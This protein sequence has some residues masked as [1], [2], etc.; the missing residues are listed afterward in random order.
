MRRLSVGSLW[1]V[2]LLLLN[3]T[4]STA[5]NPCVTLR[6]TLGD[7]VVEIFCD[8]APLTS[9]NFLRYVD[10]DRFAGA[11]F[12]RVVTLAN[13]PGD[14]ITIEVVQGGLGFAESNLRLPPVAHETTELTGIQHTDGVISMARLEPGTASSEFFFCI[15]AQPH[16]DFGG[17]RNPD[18]QGFAAFGRVVAGM[19]VLRAIHGLPRTGQFLDE[20]VNVVAIERAEFPISISP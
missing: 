9:A 2:A 3:P 11:H 19:E 7:L 5:E 18:G 13:Q 4:P 16:L 6:T 8:R 14:S 17:M 15:G 10:E 20:S 1:L 12:Y